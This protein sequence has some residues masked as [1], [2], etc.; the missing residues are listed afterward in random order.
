[1]ARQL[2]NSVHRLS[3]AEWR[4]WLQAHHGSSVGIWLV[5]Y[6]KAGG[7][8]RALDTVEALEVPADLAR[9]LDA[10]PSAGADFN[11]VPSS[12]RR[13]TLEWISNARTPATRAARVAEAAWRAEGNQRANQ[14]RGPARKGPH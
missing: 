9:A 10:C 6:K 13:S 1:M 12:A 2:P 11:A 5:A 3:R 14:R 4:A 8:W 7:S